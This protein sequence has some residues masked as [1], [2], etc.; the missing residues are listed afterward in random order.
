M[1]IVALLEPFWSSLYWDD[2]TC[3]GFVFGSKM[4]RGFGAKGFW[5]TGFRAESFRA[6]RLLE[7]YLFGA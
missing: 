6:P 4:L 2:L 3:N 5:G 7:F 1:V